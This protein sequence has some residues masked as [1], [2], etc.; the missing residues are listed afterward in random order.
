MELIEILV[1]IAHTILFGMIFLSFIDY[2]T[3]NKPITIRISKKQ[4]TPDTPELHKILKQKNCEY[5]PSLFYSDNEPIIIITYRYIDP[6]RPLRIGRTFYVV[7]SSDELLEYSYSIL[8]E[9]YS[10]ELKNVD[11]AIKNNSSERIVVDLA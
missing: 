8:K 11:N 3:R 9:K 6:K 10:N 5:Y 4:Y 1:G 7:P 2:I